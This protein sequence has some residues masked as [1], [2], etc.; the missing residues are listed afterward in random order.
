LFLLQFYYR[1]SIHCTYRQILKT[2]AKE[3]VHEINANVA[4]THEIWMSD[5]SQ[6]NNFVR[7]AVNSL[8]RS[9]SYAKEIKTLH[10]TTIH[11]RTRKEIYT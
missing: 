3:L 2:A 10:M 4:L 1:Y 7:H 9:Q 8:S 11:N 5:E 6:W